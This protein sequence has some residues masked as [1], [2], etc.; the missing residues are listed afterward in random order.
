MTGT[1][2]VLK[3]EDQAYG[4]FARYARMMRSAWTK[5]PVYKLCCVLPNKKLTVVDS[6]QTSQY[7]GVLLLPKLVSFT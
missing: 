3:R 2:I 6:V 5:S 4:I 7:G 1:S